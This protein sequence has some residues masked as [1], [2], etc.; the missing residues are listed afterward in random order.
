V[1]PCPQWGHPRAEAGA[2]EAAVTG[3]GAGVKP[4][5]PSS[6]HGEAEPLHCPVSAQMGHLPAN[7][8]NHLYWSALVT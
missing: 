7:G 5:T 3:P 4:V 6:G 2:G 8:R 1:A